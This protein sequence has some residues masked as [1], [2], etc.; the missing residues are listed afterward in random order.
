MIKQLLQFI[1]NENGDQKPNKKWNYIIILI[2]LSLLLIL[3]GK[4]FSPK[5]DETEESQPIIIEQEKE[6]AKNSSQQEQIRQTTIRE[7]ELSYEKQLTEVLEKVS[8]ISEID[9]MV[10]LD[11]TD[12]SVFEKNTM[13]GKQ[14][15]DETDKSGGIRK[16]EDTTEDQQVVIIRQGDKETPL[17]VQIKKPEVRGVLVAAKG[18]EQASTK[19][20]VIESI[21]RVLDVPT[22]RISVLSKNK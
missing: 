15:T 6:A 3:L 22:H 10:N 18:V 2:C 9:V 14:V 12:I 17:V 5:T 20:W 7:M 19:T 8:G 13:T 4:V 16:V 21:S 11:S 1:R